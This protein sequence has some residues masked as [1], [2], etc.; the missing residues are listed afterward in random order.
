[1]RLPFLNR[2]RELERLKRALASREGSFCCL[3]G[4]RRCGKSRLLRELL[5]SHTG[6]YYVGDRREANLQRAAVAEA[7]ADLLSGFADVN[8]PD[9]EP[10]LHRWWTSAPSGAVLVFDEFPAMV[11][12]SP[13]LPSLLQKLVDAHAARPVHLVI[14]GS[15]KRL[16]QGL[17]LDQ[18]EPLFGRAREILKIDALDISWLPRA[19]PVATAVEA[20]EAYAAWGGVPRYWELAGDFA[21]FWQ[22]LES[23]VLDPL[24]VLHH[25]PERLLADDMR[26]VVQASSILALVGQGCHRLSEIGGRLGKPASSL[27]R[28]VQRLVH[29]GLLR[30]ETPFGHSPRSSKSTLYTLHDP[31][32]AF[33]YRFVDP[34]RSRLGAGAV[35]AVLCDV[36]RDYP[37][38]AGAIWERV[39]RAATPR[40]E[41][42]Q[43]S[44]NSADRWW[45][46]GLD[47]QPLEIDVVAECV[48]RE[49]LLVG[50]VKLQVTEGDLARLAAELDHNT[51]RLPFAKDYARVVKRIFVGSIT[52]N[53][54]PPEGVVT[55][56]ELLS[57]E[58][59]LTCGRS[60]A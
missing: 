55:A 1:M 50:E 29:L 43:T 16:M 8:Y 54:P 21:D 41:I 17:V 46:T 28:P 20:L 32:L 37:G 34:N 2:A 38:H 15:S 57:A 22:A 7:V 25:E 30:R 11:E 60:S 14:A 3:Y 48:D 44:W 4:R 47:R 18:S 23:L 36:R 35:E 59:P 26:D 52:G 42:A 51:K 45:G 6:V 40:L 24:G 58:S 9:W 19:L 5:G 12:A 31:F 53:T 39:V 33:W 10:L 49:S 13:E 56:A 27:T